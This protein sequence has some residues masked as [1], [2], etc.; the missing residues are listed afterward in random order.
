MDP[1]RSDEDEQDCHADRADLTIDQ[2]VDVARHGAKVKLSNSHRRYMADAYTLLLEGAKQ[3]IP[4]YRFNRGAGAGREDV[5]FEGDP[6]SDVNRQALYD[7]RLNAARNSALS[8]AGPR[9]RARRSC[10]R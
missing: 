4:I 2:V 7:R 8:P 10:A 9:W 3:G 5:I 1:D 6:M